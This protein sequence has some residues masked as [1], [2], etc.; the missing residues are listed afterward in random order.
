VRHDLALRRARRWFSGRYEN[1][2]DDGFAIPAGKGRA[3][4]KKGSRG[5]VW[6]DVLGNNSE[7]M[8]RAEVEQRSTGRVGVAETKGW[9]HM[10]QVAGDR[11]VRRSRHM[12]IPIPHGANRARFGRVMCKTNRNLLVNV[13]HQVRIPL[14]GTVGVCV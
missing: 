1:I 13:L 3:S 10:E 12:C 6:I 2:V 9:S 7:A 8:S 14:L 5:Q 4:Q 11:R